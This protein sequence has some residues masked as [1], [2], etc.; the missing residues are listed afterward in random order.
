MGIW[1]ERDVAKLAYVLGIVLSQPREYQVKIDFKKVIAW[2]TLKLESRYTVEEI[3]AA[4]DFFT[5]SQEN[6]SK[7]MQ[8]CDVIAI[9]E[10]MPRKI[11]QTEYLAALDWQKRE[12]NFSEFTDQAY[13]IKA[14]KN[15]VK[16]EKHISKAELMAAS[17]LIERIKELKYKNII[18]NKAVLTIEGK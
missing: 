3:I 14:Y 2:W 4:I 8:P 9:L 17:D 7:V 18:E 1:T 15:Q 12:G 16:E 13:A 11:T 5:D 6:S 10:E